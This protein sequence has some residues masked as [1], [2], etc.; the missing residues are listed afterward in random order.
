MTKHTYTEHFAQQQKNTHPSQARTEHS[1]RQN[2]TL[3]Q[4]RSLNKCKNIE[5]IS[6]LFS[7]HNVMKLEI[8]SQSKPGKFTNMWKLN[9]ALLNNPQV[10]E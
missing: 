3:G 4:E 1:P 5:I 6:S 9:K 8:K 7:R 2:H 10:E